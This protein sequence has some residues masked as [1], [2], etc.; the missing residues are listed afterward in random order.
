MTELNQDLFEIQI[1]DDTESEHIA[2]P[3]YS[4][5]RSVFR[6]F[7]SSKLAIFMMILSGTV[8]LLSIIQPMFSGYDPNITP[9]I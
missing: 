4:Y 1:A 8:I 7:F 9:N 3:Q 6:K 2:A 5:W